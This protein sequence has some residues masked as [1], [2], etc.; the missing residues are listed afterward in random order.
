[1]M[2]ITEQKNQK[3][4]KKNKNKNS[5]TCNNQFYDLTTEIN[6]D[7]S[8]S[9]LNL[10]NNSFESDNS[11]NGI[12]EIDEINK[13]FSLNSFETTHKCNNEIN[14]NKY[15]LPHVNDVVYNS[16]DNSFSKL[17]ECLHCDKTYTTRKILKAH[18]DSVHISGKKHKCKCGKEYFYRHNLKQHEMK[19]Q[20][21]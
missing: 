10:N 11:I 13:I 5:L 12:N 16:L 9:K 19:C 14:V 18:I 17:Y 6:E 21:A 7:N 1:K 8:G 20:Q 3:K 4:F 2:N 15:K